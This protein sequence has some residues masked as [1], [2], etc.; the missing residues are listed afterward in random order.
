VTI[1]P[2]RYSTIS[3]EFKKK[4]DQP[5]FNIGMVANKESGLQYIDDGKPVEL[6]KRGFNHFI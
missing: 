5:L 1:A 6:H 2:E 4:F 3:E